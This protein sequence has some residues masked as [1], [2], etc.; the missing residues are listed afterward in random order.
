MHTVHLQAC[1]ATKQE[2]DILNTHDSKCFPTF[3]SCNLSSVCNISFSFLDTFTADI[4]H[5]SHTLSVF[6]FPSHP[7]IMSSGDKSKSSSQT[8]GKAAQGKKSEMGMMSYKVGGFCMEFLSE[9][10]EIYFVY[11]TPHAC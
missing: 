9:P 5:L 7:V 8:D 11:C 10:R 4:L 3:Y 6:F 1:K 2:I